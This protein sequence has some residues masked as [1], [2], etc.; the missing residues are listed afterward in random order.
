[1]P[2]VAN[3]IRFSETPIAPVLPPPLLGEHT[4]EILKE[5]L[6]LDETAI[7]R[8]AADRVIRQ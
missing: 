3:P 6:G 2:Q 8:L 5:V 7:E 1:V 4:S